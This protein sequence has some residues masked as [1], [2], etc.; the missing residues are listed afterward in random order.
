MASWYLRHFTCEAAPVCDEAADEALAAARAAP[1]QAER[2]AR[3]AEA[4]GILT[5]LTPFIA[6]ASPV[7]WSLVGPRLTG[8]RPNPFAR[9]PAVTLIA[10]PR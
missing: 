3:L 1:S 8:F 7:R 2:Q 5:G 9:H 4:D 6:L 10:E